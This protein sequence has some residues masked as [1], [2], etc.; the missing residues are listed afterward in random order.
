MVDRGALEPPYQQIAGIL[1]ARIES[2][3]LEPGARLPSVEQLVGEYGVARITARKA[4]R[5]LV[6]E[7]LAVM[8]PGWGTFVAKRQ[9]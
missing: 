8:Q 5:V 1:R 6:D 3:D 4:L 2:G 7:G 9:R